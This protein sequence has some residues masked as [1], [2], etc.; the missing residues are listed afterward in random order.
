KKGHWFWDTLKRSREI[1]ASVLLGSVMINMSVLVTPIFTMNVYDRVVPNGA[2]ETLWFLAIGVAVVYCFDAVFRFIRNYLIEVAGKKGD[3]IMS[4]LVFERVLNL[5][6]EHWPKSVGAF[7]SVLGQ[8]ESIRNFFTASTMVTFVDLPFSFLFLAVVAYIGDALVSIP[9][10]TMALLMLYGMLIVRPLRASI[11]DVFAASAMKNSMLVESL[12]SIRT[13]KTLGASGH[14]QWAWE[15]TT[16]EIATKSLRA[17]MLSGSIGVVT[18]I[19]M[20][21]NMVAIVIAGVYLIMDL[22]LTLGAL[23]AVVL[24]SGRA[25]APMAQVASLVTNYQ[26]TKAS[27]ESME[28]LMNT[29]V[30]R[31]DNKTYV[32]RSEIEGNIQFEEVEFIYPDTERAILSQFSL[33]VSPGEHVGVI[34]RVGSGKTTFAKLLLGLYTPSAGALTLDGID[35][36]QIDPV[37]LRR[38]IAYMA[39]DTELMR[40]TIRENIT[41]KNPRAEDE[42]ILKAAHIGGVDLFVNAMPLGF[43]TPVGEQGYALSSGQRQCVALARTVL[44]GENIIILD[45]PTNSMDNTTESLIRKRLREYTRDRTLLLVTHKAPMLELV[46]RLVVVEGGRIIMDGPKEKVLTALQQRSSAA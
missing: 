6:M 27:F 18:H 41:L 20:Q 36:N 28:R 31:P 43:D 7:T 2:V 42:E 40:G 21:L 34:G 8:F 19:L 1:Y 45:E 25:I 26:Q 13:I 23:I 3:I 32:R 24:L 14:A 46:E 22:E 4:S 17:R 12:H 44:S 10:V 38:S 16:G 39:Q 29:E 37:D 30:E 33:K 9:L 15:E 5:R 35:I 11:K